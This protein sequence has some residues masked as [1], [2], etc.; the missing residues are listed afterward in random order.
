MK[1]PVCRKCRRERT[2]LFLKGDR[3]ISAKCSITKRP[4]PPG[5]TAQITQNR[6]SEYCRQLRAKQKA[7]ITYGISEK[8]LFNYYK[9]ATKSIGKTGEAILQLLE[10]RLDNIVYKLG[11]AS[12]HAQ[13]RQMVSHKKITINDKIINI[14]SYRV[15]ENDKVKTV[16]KIINPKKIELPVWLELDKNKEVGKIVKFPLREEINTDVDEQLIV[17]YYSR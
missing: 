13:A 15:N 16:K 5:H 4:Y 3:C 14:A 6:P 12:S 8:Q 10:T 7:K 11:F 1:N 9:E 17:E 2:K